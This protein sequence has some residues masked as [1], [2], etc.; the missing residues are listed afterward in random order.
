LQRIF[1]AHGLE[2]FDVEEL[3]THGGSLRIFIAH[4]GSHPVM[5]NVSTI[6]TQE[7]AA[8]L[9]T[10]EAYSGFGKKITQICHALSKFLDHAKSQNK[11]ALAYGA[12]AKGN[13]LLNV[14]KI[15]KDRIGYVVDKNPH[16]QGRFLP[17]SH[18]PIRLPA[19]I[20]TTKPDYL[21]ILPW[22]LKAEISA[23]MAGISEWGG[24]FV[25]AIP[26]LRIWSTKG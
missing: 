4:R 15:S 5:P 14:S 21:L 11:T 19:D 17:G 13:T 1:A 20:F 7:Q 16:K 12:A 24:Q 9:H 22:N 18:L 6:L 8:G 25:T 26:E 23:E 3:P 2:I 10:M